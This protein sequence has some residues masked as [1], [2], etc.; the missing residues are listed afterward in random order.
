MATYLGAFPFP[1][2]APCILTREAMIKVVTV[3]TERYGKVLRRGKRD[4]VKLLFRSMAVFDRRSSPVLPASEKP[5][6][7]QLV[8]EQKPDDMVQEEAG[9]KDV[10]SHVTG[11]AID[12]PA[13]DDPDEEEDDDELALAALD[14]LD[15]IE[16]FKHDQKVTHE[17]KIHNARIPVENF[18]RILMLLL[19]LA[20]LGPQE[21]LAKY[22]EVLSE[23]RLAEYE[24]EVDSVVAS[25]DPDEVTG[26]I[27]YAAFTR[28]I[29]TCF[30]LLFDPFN[31][32][33]EH[34]LF[35]KNINLSRHQ[36]S[37]PS[38][39]PP[40]LSPKINPIVSDSSGVSLILTPALLSHLSTFLITQPS[41][42]SP[43]NLFHAGTRFHPVYS[44]TA[45]GTSLTS[46]SRHVMSWQ[47][48]TLLLITGTQRPPPHHS[49][50]T[51]SS[52]QLITIGAFLPNPWSKPA[53]MSSSDLQPLLFL[54]SPRHALFPHNPYNHNSTSISHFGAKSG[55]SLGC[56]I[57]PSSRTNSV[58][59]TPILGPVSLRIDADVSTAVFQ[60]DA[61]EG[62][63]AFLTDPG[64]EKTQMNA[65][66][67]H[68][69]GKA[70]ASANQL[71]KK[72]EFDIDTLEIWGVT[73]E[74][75]DGGEEGNE[76]LKQKNRMEWEEKEAARRAAVNFGGDKDGARALLEMAGLVGDKRR[77]G[78]S[79]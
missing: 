28:A 61:E 21:N 51:P 12:E 44:T 67:R 48:A 57:P 73:N 8:A 54:L 64:L 70:D 23:A 76:V 31:A 5:T 42:T 26:G 58:S 6:M 9:A 68:R 11:F 75:P 56:I 22:V 52:T 13:N 78:G 79:V 25:F 38:T 35:S 74:D 39:P 20:P 49:N 45:Q 19:V 63:G 71:A 77:S 66:D 65:K 15:A 30:P 47:S 1:S 60:H 46:F 50:T 18:K 40:P 62:V 59:H 43:V 53:T 72:I 14:S 10:R 7:E 55:I 3:M 69:S 41:S 36:K 37:A 17:K 2:L 4:R 29:S 32:L 27:R 33:F 16:V 24:S 34:F